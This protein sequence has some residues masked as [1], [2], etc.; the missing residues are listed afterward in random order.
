MPDSWLKSH[1]SNG[2]WIMPCGTLLVCALLVLHGL[3]AE[4]L[5]KR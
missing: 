5:S 2:P 3:I 1:K 4:A